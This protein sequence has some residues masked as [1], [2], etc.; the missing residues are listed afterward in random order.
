LLDDLASI[1]RRCQLAYSAKSFSPQTAA[2][3]L[4]E[5]VRVARAHRAAHRRGR[6]N[7]PGSALDRA[8]T[9][10]DLLAVKVLAQLAAPLMP[11]FAARLWSALGCAGEPKWDALAALPEGQR[12]TEPQLFFEPLPAD[13]PVLAMAADRQ[14]VSS[15]G[16]RDAHD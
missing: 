16:G 6:H 10:G 15:A 8:A 2:R 4:V 11:S 3:Q 5:L 7:R 14:A 9:A 1:A 12:V 13:L